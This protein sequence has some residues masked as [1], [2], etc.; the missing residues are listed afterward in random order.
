MYILP[1]MT[2]FTHA[3]NLLTDVK[4]FGDMSPLKYGWGTPAG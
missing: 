1:F 3:D 4:I 2:V